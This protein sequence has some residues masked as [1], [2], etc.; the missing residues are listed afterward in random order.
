M[1]E[2]PI[3]PGFL[4]ILIAHLPYALGD[5]VAEDDDLAALGLDSMGVVQLV[6]DLEETFGFELPDELL[7]EDSFA[8]A[9]SL[10]AAV[11]EFVAPEPADV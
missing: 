2:S 3:P 5:R 11:A 7:T 10:W 6:T 8:T 4:E 1:P 9:G